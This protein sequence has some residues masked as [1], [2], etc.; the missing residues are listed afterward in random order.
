VTASTTCESCG[1]PLLQ[2]DDH[3]LG[4]AASPY[5]R[6]CT[7]ESGQLQL[8]EERFERTTQWA[9]RRDGLPRAE[10][11]ARARAYMRGMPAWKD[12]PALQEG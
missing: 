9:V 2:A 12:H 3:A 6:Y 11:E 10:A 8:F 5:C 4:D 1:L 7:D